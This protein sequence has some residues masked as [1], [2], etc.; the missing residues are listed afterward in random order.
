MLKSERHVIRGMQRDMTVS[1]FNPEYAFDAQNIRLTA[2]ENHTLLS[3]TNEKGNLEV[4]LLSGDSVIS[5]EGVALGHCVLKDYIVV[6]TKSTEDKIYRITKENGAFKATVLYSGDLNFSTDYPI[7]TLGSYE[8]ENIQK[9]YWVDGLNQ[10]RMINIVGDTSNYNSGSFNFIR[11]VDLNHVITVTKNPISSGYFSSGVIQ[12]AIS[13]YVKYA[14]E[15]TIFYMSPLLYI[16]PDGRGGS[17][18]EVCNCS[19]QLSLSDLDQSFDGVNIYSIQRTSLNGTPSVKLLTSLSIPR[20]GETISYIDNGTTGSTVDPTELLYKGGEEVTPYTITQ[21]DNTL[22]LGNLTIKRSA[23]PQSIREEIATLQVEAFSKP[24]VS[25]N[26]MSNTYYPYKG[27]LDMDSYTTTTFKSGETYRLGLIFLHKTGK[28]SEAIF[29]KDAVMNLSILYDAINGPALN[30]FNSFIPEST[31][32]QL[33]DLGYVGVRPVVVFPS[34]SDRSILCQGVVCPTVFNGLERSDNSPYSMSSWFARP[35]LFSTKNNIDIIR[36]TTD[37]SIANFQMGEAIGDRAFLN[38]DYFAEIQGNNNFSVDENV[39]TFH[40]PDIEFD[41]TVRKTLSGAK[42]KIVGIAKTINNLIDYSIVG[43][44][45]FR[46]DATSAFP[47]EVVN[48][49]FSQPYDLTL[50]LGLRRLISAPLWRDGVITTSSEGS[51][52]IDNGSS[53]RL[54]AA[55]MVYPWGRDTSLNND[56]RG[57]S[58]TALLNKKIM[59]TLVY[60]EPTYLS[61]NNQFKFEVE[62]DSYRTGISGVTIFDSN[63]VVIERLPIPLNSNLTEQSVYQGN[64]SNS[65]VNLSSGSIVEYPIMAT[66]LSNLTESEDYAFFHDDK[67]VATRVVD[68]PY[69]PASQTLLNPLS[70]VYPKR[71]STDAV[72]IKFK[73]TA[74]AVIQFNGSKVYNKIVLPSVSNADR[75]RSYDNQETYLYPPQEE[76]VSIVFM[77]PIL[78]T[79]PPPGSIGFETMTSQSSYGTLKYKDSTGWHP[80]VNPSIE[81]TTYYMYMGEVYHLMKRHSESY[82]YLFKQSDILTFY[83]ENIEHLFNSST[84]EE[85]AFYIAELYRDDVIN[86][87]GGNT[88]SAYSNN[89]WLPCGKIESLDDMSSITFEEGDTYFQ[90]Y[91]H[92]KT[93]AFDSS[94]KNNVVEILSFLCETRVNID[95]RYDRNRGLKNNLS[96]SPQNFNLF[97]PVYSQQNNF[98]SYRFLDSDLA[99]VNRFPNTVTWSSEKTNGSITDPWTNIT[100]LSTLDMDGDKGEIISLNNY[101]NELFCFQEQG[102]SNII[103]NPRVQ[104]PASDGLPI[105]ITNNYKVQGKRYISS[106]I[107]CN[108]KWSICISSRGIYFIDSYTNGLYLFSGE[109][110]TSLS[111]K[112]GFRQ[113]IGSYS[114]MDKWDPVNYRNFRTFHDKTNDDVYFINGDTCL[115]YSEFLQQFTS[116]MSYEKVP[117][118]FNYQE[119]FYSV[120]NNKMWQ[121]NAGDYNM[122]FG[123]FKPYSIT[124]VANAEEPNDKIFNTVEFRSD[125]W[126]GDTLLNNK[127]FDYLKVWNEYQEGTTPLTNLIAHPSPLKKKFRI[128][129]AIIPRDNANKRDRIRN[130]WAY[131]QLAMNTPNTYRTEFHDANIHYFV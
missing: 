56:F 121:Q 123:S 48:Y 88:D 29:L 53:N 17:P 80:V 38:S 77:G 52:E 62:N 34:Y 36:A 64:Y 57:Y 51:N 103:F 10:A 110:I 33:K 94:S 118:M 26:D 130:T 119:K 61:Q 49:D 27:Y 41:D 46:T 84:K 13:Y 115:C 83:K 109:G 74:H 40:S 44:S 70:V 68:A 5:L 116:F 126:D 39:V 45:Y 66:G 87:F 6:F 8:N 117:L 93:Y 122:F 90:R 65:V 104:I 100:M 131:V 1:Q 128:W 37:G 72:N 95:G 106:N 129:R 82:Y 7:E 32:N 11:D 24:Q 42:L 86:R 85:G 102:I 71:Y 60:T 108:N 18:E 97:N 76:T 113:F 69:L 67:F 59:S 2:R 23:I 127:T 98:F 43:G 105:E 73:S 31:I 78:P 99:S 81:G 92:L 9:V 75:P 79:A 107:G 89:I 91:D 125:S 124:M 50:P 3:V 21:K 63:E 112:L 20:S 111:D 19:F 114:T 58:G 4:D 15:S 55:F 12:Y 101:N 47:Y 54:H 25:I 30:R 16:S 22:F 28:W 120:K 96:M 35:K 14:Q